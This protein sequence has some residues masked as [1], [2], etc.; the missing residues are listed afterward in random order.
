MTD[1]RAAARIPELDGLRGVAILAVV[2][3][4]YAFGRLAPAMQAG[5][6]GVS[7]F[8]VLSGFL[9]TTILRR[10][11]SQPGYY[12]RFWDRRARR[13]WPL[14]YT[15]LLAYYAATWWLAPELLGRSFWIVFALFLQAI[16]PPSVPI[17]MPLWMQHLVG[18]VWSLSVEEWFYV[19][20]G[21]VVRV[22]TRRRL[23]ALCVALIVLEPA[24][25]AV[26]H[27][28]DFPEYF[29]FV[30]RADSLAWGALAAILVEEP[31]ILA[32]L[33][34]HARKVI[35]I[36]GAVV[37]AT[38]WWT[39][40][41]DRGLFRMAIL[42]YSCLDAACAAVVV[43]FVATTGSRFWP[44]RL[45]RAGWLR[46]AGT[47]SYGM[48]LFHMP[49]FDL[50]RFVLSADS[51]LTRLTALAATIAMASLSWR[52]F[53]APILNAGRTRDS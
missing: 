18:I 5:W 48:Y 24:V 14:A 15:V 49:A 20:W 40:S 19:V 26:V 7:L 51:R 27:R 39:N 33:R 12:R 4:H 35:W 43:S 2:A 38:G 25:R 36:A 23:I 42:G 46:H 45:C 10:L 28:P 30:T 47:I 29:L 31:R 52:Y 22:F 44:A 41:G 8:F 3:S 50:A 37:L 16:I 9:I 1:D 11:R 32:M 53:E 34:C 17:G 21:P 13:V 6:A